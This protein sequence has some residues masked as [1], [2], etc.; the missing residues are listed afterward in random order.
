MSCVVKMFAAVAAALLTYV[1]V[2]AGGLLALAAT[3]PGYGAAAPTRGFSFGML[4]ARLVVAMVA[5]LAAGAV[6]GRRQGVRAAWVAG[7]VVLAVASYRHL[8]LLWAPYPAWYH[9][10]YLLPLVPAMVA[11]A[12]LA[13]SGER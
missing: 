7:I 9:A 11:A 5:A 6:A 1:V 10:A 13:R 4:S 2:G 8:V 3:W 12:A